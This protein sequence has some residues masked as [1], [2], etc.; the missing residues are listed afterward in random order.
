MKENKERLP[1]KLEMTK[2]CSVRKRSLLLLLIGL[3]CHPSQGFQPTIRSTSTKSSSVLEYKLKSTLKALPNSDNN[4][5]I[6][7]TDESSLSFEKAIRSGWQPSR[8]Y[9][10]GLKRR[11]QDGKVST[12]RNMSD[13]SG[14]IMPDGGLSPCIIKVVG[15][16]G[17]GCNAVSVK[18]ET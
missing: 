5:S 6:I 4:N 18:Y 15:V 14:A 2:M 16:G 3:A 1:P 11:H 8:G 12:V 9:F 17:G 13:T 10:S 7:N